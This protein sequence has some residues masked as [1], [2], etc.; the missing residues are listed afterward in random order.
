MKTKII[1]VLLSL[2]I[3]TNILYS[4]QINK[5]NYQLV[6][7]NED[8]HEAIATL[9]TKEKSFILIGFYLEEQNM[10]LLKKEIDI[11]NLN[12]HIA[13]IVINHYIKN[14]TYKYQ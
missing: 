9:K 6:F 3:F 1:L 7:Y 14:A 12:E 8:T 10:F 2:L 13:S 11:T 5:K 4:F